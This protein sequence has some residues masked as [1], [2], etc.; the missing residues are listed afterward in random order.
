MSPEKG[1]VY[2]Q[3]I[4]VTG[5]NSSENLAAGAPVIRSLRAVP[6][7][8]GKVVALA[9]DA[10]DAGLYVPGLVDTSYLLP[11]PSQGLAAL[12]ARLSHVATQTPLDLII[13]CLDSEL[14][15]FIRLES[16]LTAQGIHTLLPTEEQLVARTKANLAGLTARCGVAVPETRV[17]F[18]RGHAAQG[19]A[20]LPFPIVVKGCFCEA[21]VAYTPAQAAGYFDRLAMRWGVPVIVQEYLT[22]IEFNVAALGDSTGKMLGAVAMRKVILSNTG[23][24]WSGVTIHDPTLLTLV[25]DIFTGLRWRGPIEI[26]VLKAAR[27]GQWYL[28]EI[29]PRFPAW[30]HL[31]TA[32]G[33][34]LP[35]ATVR[36]A[37]GEVVQPFTTYAAGLRYVRY[38]QDMIC[39]PAEFDRLT[40]IGE[41][42]WE[43]HDERTI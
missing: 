28:L 27:D 17:V 19:L 2:P 32:A 39:D 11:Y 16:F 31:A 33:Q 24:A 5:L 10:L 6:A 3:N 41:I 43:D 35:F 1:Q 15:S 20:G 23:K 8:T 29:N 13:P 22:G 9:Y 4:A 25:Q 26:E 18:T 14:Q 30:I 40:A 42:R 21:Y 34:N 12:T 36:A 37:L 7:F 38:A